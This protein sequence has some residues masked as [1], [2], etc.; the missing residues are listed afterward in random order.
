MLDKSRGRKRPESVAIAIA[1]ASIKMSRH[2]K[3]NAREETVPAEFFFNIN[4]DIHETTS[5]D[6]R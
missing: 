3:V 4:N 2:S 5:N 1:K 6:N